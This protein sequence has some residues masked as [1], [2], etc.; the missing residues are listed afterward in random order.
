VRFHSALILNA[1]VKEIEPG[2]V[3][4]RFDIE[5]DDLSKLQELASSYAARVTVFSEHLGFQHLHAL[6]AQFQLRLESGVS[7]QVHPPLPFPTPSLSAAT[8]RFT[9][10]NALSLAFTS[11]AVIVVGVGQAA[12]AG[13]SQARTSLV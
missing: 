10:L 2:V 3:C 13:A 4:R 1:V 7:K 9:P 11:P 12:V 6:L 8:G 5:P